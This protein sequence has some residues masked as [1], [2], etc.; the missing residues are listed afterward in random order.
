M[1]D[2]CAAL[3]E[4]DDILP[5]QS[6]RRV[7][8][9]SVQRSVIDQLRKCPKPDA[10]MANWYEGA[11]WARQDTNNPDRLPQAAH[12]LR[13]LLQ[14]LP[15][16]LLNA[17]VIARIDSK[18]ARKKIRERLKADHKQYPECNWEDA[19]ITPEFARTL[20]MLIEYIEANEQPTRAEQLANALKSVDPMFG[21]VGPDIVKRKT[22]HYIAVWHKV[23]AVAHHGRTVDDAGFDALLDEV[24][25][26]IL[27]LVAPVAVEDQKEIL[28][29]L[30]AGVVD[31][32]TIR[33][34]KKL[35]ELR[36]GANFALFFQKLEDPNWLDPLVAEGFFK[37]APAPLAIDGST[38]IQAW[39]PANAL[40]RLVTKAE[41]KVV[42]IALTLEVAGNVRV[43]ED[44][45][46]VAMKAPTVNIS[47]RLN[48]RVLEYFNNPY[49]WRSFEIG[50]TLLQNWSVTGNKPAITSALELAECL[51]RL[52]DTESEPSPSRRRSTGR[53]Q[54]VLE[55][56][57]YRDLVENALG[58]LIAVAPKEVAEMVAATLAHITK[59]EPRMTG[60][61]EFAWRD[62]SEL[63]CP[64]VTVAKFDEHDPRAQL[65]HLLFRAASAV[66]A[67]DPASFGFIGDLLK[68]TDTQLFDRIFRAICSAN[69]DHAEAE[70]RAEI[71]TS[72]AYGLID[73]DFEFCQLIETA[74][75]RYGAKFLDEAQCSTIIDK[76][77]AGPSQKNFINAG[78]PEEAEA[79][80]QRARAHF[81]LKQM[82]PFAPILPAKYREYF[83]G[84][85]KDGKPAPSSANYGRGFEG[86]GGMVVQRSVK[87]AEELAAMA[88]EDLVKFLNDW[89]SPGMHR[90][91]FLVENSFSG[92]SK[93][94]G[95]VVQGNPARFAAWK[96]AWSSLMRPIYV[97][98]ALEAAKRLVTEGTHDHGPQWLELCKYVIEQ[99]AVEGEDSSDTPTWLSCRR[100]VNDFIEMAVNKKHAIPT[101]FAPEIWALV[102][103][104]CLSAD[105]QLD[106]PEKHNDEAFSTAINRTRSRALEVAVAV[107]DWAGDPKPLTEIL[108]K[109][110]AGSPALTLPERALLAVLIANIVH[111][112]KAWGTAN[113]AR[114]FPRGKPEEWV[115]I[116]D[117]FLRYTTPHAFLL[118][119]VEQELECAL[120]V[121]SAA[122]MALLGQHRSAMDSL[123][124][125]CFLYYAVID[126]PTG[127]TQKLLNRFIEVATPEQRATLFGNVGRVIS[128]A[129]NLAP[130]IRDRILAYFEVRLANRDSNEL[131]N[132]TLWLD[133]EC[134]DA[135][136]R[137]KAYSAL[138]SKPDTKTFQFFSEVQALAKLAPTHL[139]LVIECFDKITELIPLTKHFYIRTEDGKAIIREALKSSNFAIR[140][141][142]ERAQSNLL[143]NGFQDY[144]NAFG[145]EGRAPTPAR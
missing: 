124:Q 132:F 110:F 24:N 27:G 13:D 129:D 46:N 68:K 47:I 144:L 102:R 81:H 14:E 21:V 86:R 53:F 90:G 97:Q 69:I 84:L 79:R 44:I 133:A 31:P 67:T 88:D 112:D 9:T 39:W 101:K 123:G 93:A 106:Q 114:F 128:N 36:G 109:R 54:P 10:L 72:K 108:D 85:E 120:E 15:K 139:G 2:D 41:D 22:K 57:D 100:E 6:P 17:P 104:I 119:F 140:L 142:G 16:V 71:V 125:H 127:A 7:V 61:G 65:A 126:S 73:Y 63:S 59:V 48:D 12:S 117:A 134:L 121:F 94:F 40:P 111:L 138:L 87:S 51:L 23:Q 3:A 35:I 50:R 70:S 116:V 66:V 105:P 62:Y 78:T 8:L 107:A 77:L 45:A 74:V 1:T 135:A 64:N 136:W 137:L 98:A 25:D 42:E 20:D 18:S 82:A 60:K 122:D 115:A 32:T 56:H 92:L 33:R 113:H 11:L 75:A 5:S 4:Q 37:G 80:W 89:N 55:S 143:K 95:E 30:K 38:T 91:D 43:L 58:P 49:G 29:I 141:A 118:P 34:I 26:L 130:A 103:E 131:E 96:P 99:P 83:D 52:V 28:H 76:I 19:E 145:D